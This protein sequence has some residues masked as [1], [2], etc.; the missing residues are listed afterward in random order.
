MRLSAFVVVL[1]LAGGIVLS[2]QSSATVV[3]I[4]EGRSRAGL[5]VA[6]AAPYQGG[7]WAGVPANPLRPESKVTASTFRIRAWKEGQRARVVVFAVIPEEKDRE[8]ETQIA[9]FLIDPGQSVEVTET[10]QY[11]AAHV[12]VSAAAEPPR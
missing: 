6:V 9:T 12:T 2:A 4:S 11:G 7:P 3:S 8:K 1:G 10:D 5:A